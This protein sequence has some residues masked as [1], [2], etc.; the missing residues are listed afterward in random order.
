VAYTAT[1]KS[2]QIYGTLVSG[3]VLIAF[4]DSWFGMDY[5]PRSA[6]DG[7]V[8]EAGK[9]TLWFQIGVLGIFPSKKT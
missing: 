7:L 1:E 2:I 4:T 3:A 6:I 5:V 8:I 9:V